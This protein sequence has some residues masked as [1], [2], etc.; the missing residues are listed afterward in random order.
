MS[1]ELIR[2]NECPLIA[3]RNCD[4]HFNGHRSGLLYAGF[5][6]FSEQLAY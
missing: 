5:V 1:D 3:R 6:V 4:E 2:K